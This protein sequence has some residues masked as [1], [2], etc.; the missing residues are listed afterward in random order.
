MDLKEECLALV[1]KLLTE[2]TSSTQIAIAIEEMN[3]L[4]KALIK[5]NF[6]D[7]NNTNDV[8]EELGDV[9][10]CINMIMYIYRTN[11]QEIFTILYKKLQ[12]RGLIKP[13]LSND[14]MITKYINDD[15]INTYCSEIDSKIENSN[16][17]II[18]EYTTDILHDSAIINYYLNGQI[19]KSN[20]NT[21]EYLICEYFKDNQLV[22][23]THKSH[24]DGSIIYLDLENK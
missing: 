2:S 14:I 5:N 9:L 20:T 11:E 17:D 21:F 7:K 13:N 22:Q 3:E 24:Y 12:D 23:K 4:T 8:F 16:R 6:R 18:I 1:P 15:V 19:V 10:F